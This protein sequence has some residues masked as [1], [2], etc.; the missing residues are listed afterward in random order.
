[1]D[2]STIKK[3]ND[4]I[5]IKIKFPHLERY[6]TDHKFEDNE[7]YVEVHYYKK[8]IT[9]SID[10]ICFNIYLKD[11]DQFLKEINQFNLELKKL[12][13]E[14]IDNILKNNRCFD[15]DTYYYYV[16]IGIDLGI[17]YLRL[18]NI[19]KEQ[20]RLEQI[21]EAK[22]HQIKYETDEKYRHKYDWFNGEERPYG[23]AFDSW[24]DFYRWKNG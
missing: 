8:E 10:K 14:T 21:E 20:E 17:C 24:D 11:K 18:Y 9:Y 16:R 15:A 5:L 2:S 4:S 7:T 22:E 3:L 1:M 6:K 19:N 12:Q 13:K 23:G